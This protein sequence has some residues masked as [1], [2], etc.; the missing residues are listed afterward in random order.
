MAI[1]AKELPVYSTSPP[2]KSSAH[3]RMS[4]I[5][6]ELPTSTSSV[7]WNGHHHQWLQKTHIPQKPCDAEPV[8][9]EITCFLPSSEVSEMQNTENGVNN[10]FDGECM[11]MTTSVQN[12]QSQHYKNYCVLAIDGSE[13]MNT[14]VALRLEL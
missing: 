3:F 1:G 4:F 12:Q 9:F 5:C 7:Q 6:T 10:C 14:E 11:H 2:S 8:P 13:G